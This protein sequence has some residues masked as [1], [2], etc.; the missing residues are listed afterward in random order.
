MTKK[1]TPAL[2]Q[3]ILVSNHQWLPVIVLSRNLWPDDTVHTYQ[4]Q[5]ER[6]LDRKKVDGFFLIYSSDDTP[7]THVIASL[8]MGYY[9]FPILVVDDELEPWKIYESV[10]QPLS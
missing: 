6:L 1:T 5:G 3:Y 9:H 7:C 8:M 2:Y 10:G 4:R